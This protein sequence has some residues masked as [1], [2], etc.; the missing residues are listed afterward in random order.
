MRLL[1]KLRNFIRSEGKPYLLAERFF[2][3]RKKKALVNALQDSKAEFGIRPHIVISLT[4]YPARFNT[5]CKTLKSL[6]N[7]NMKPDRIIVYLDVADETV[8]TEMR[9]LEKYGIEYRTGME[10][11]KLHTKYFFAMQEFPQSLIIT[12]DDDLFY[13]KDLV[14]SLFL[15]WKKHP[16][17]VCARRVHKM[18]FNLNGD[19]NPYND[20]IHEYRSPVPSHLLVATGIGGVLYPP[21]CLDSRAFDTK[22]IKTNCLDADDIWLKTMA[23]LNNTKVF[24]VQNAMVH[25]PV[26]EGSQ[27]TAL[28][29][30][31][32][33][34]NRNDLYIANME[35]LFGEEIRAVLHARK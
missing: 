14:R 17:C 9:D 21:H 13:P 1:R 20:W 6:L 29:Y 8:T 35:R 26:V 19:L 34:E 22:L 30:M 28:Q 2:G 24:W 10:N 18:T 15:G 5:V 3:A 27:K 16:D 11:L 23:L 31:N 33:M 12:V 32:V 4:S 25:P 7:Q